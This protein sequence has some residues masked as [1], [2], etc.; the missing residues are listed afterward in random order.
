MIITKEAL[1]KCKNGDPE[2]QR[3]LFEAYK[4]FV[5][6]ICKRYAGSKFETEDIFQEAF[7]RIF[8]RIGQLHNLGKI[9][10]WLRQITV[11]TAINHYY[12]HRRHAGHIDIEDY[13]GANENYQLIL[14]TLTNDMLVKLIGEL[15]EGYRLVFNLFVVEGYSHG[16][17]AEMLGITEATSRSQLSRAKLALKKMLRSLG[18]INY[19]KYA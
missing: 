12:K 1:T 11:N 18:I 7:V 8:Q 14:S 6:G 9:E 5:F 16:E 13:G 4:G 2:A 10:S 17:I 19:E 3:V 15:P